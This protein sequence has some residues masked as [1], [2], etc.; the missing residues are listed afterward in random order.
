MQCPFCGDTH[1][2]GTAVCPQ[3]QRRLAGILTDGTVVDGKY[4]ISGIIGVG[5]MAAVYRAENTKIG[6]IVALK[7]LLPEY[8]VYPE[9][10]ARVDRE[11]R[12]AGGIDHPNVVAIVDLGTTAD[13]GPYI[14]MELLKGEEL[15]TYL[16][17]RG[18]T[19][20]PVEAVEITRQVLGA[21]DAAHARGVVHRDLK[22]ENIFL[23]RVD[24]DRLTVKVL[25]F[26]ISKLGKEEKG[27]SSLTRTGTVMGTPQ[28]MAPEQAAGAREQDARVDI[29]ACGAVLYAMLSNALP[30]NAE[31]Y[32]LLINE[33]LNKPATP[34]LDRVPRLDVKLASIV[35]RAIARRPD[36]RY[37]TARAMQDALLTWLD[38][39][40][41]DREPSSSRTIGSAVT[42]PASAIP[43]GLRAGGTR[44]PRLGSSPGTKPLELR[45]PGAVPT[46]ASSTAGSDDPTRFA[47]APPRSRDLFDSV[48]ALDD[49]GEDHG[50]PTVADL[51]APPPEPL[52]LPTPRRSDTRTP[53]GW[54]NTPGGVVLPR[55]PRGRGIAI[56]ALLVIAIIAAGAALRTYDPMAW[57]KAVATV[58]LNNLTV[59]APSG[60]TTASQP[61]T[62]ATTTRGAHTH[63][64]VPTNGGTQPGAHV[65][66]PGADDVQAPSNTV[67]PTT[68]NV[69]NGT[70]ANPAANTTGT[71]RA[72]GRRAPTRNG[73][74]GPHRRPTHHTR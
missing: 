32:N 21:L 46:P 23:A 72:T 51:A 27:V 3:T 36:Q 8:V 22:P 39:N 29:Y 67:E 57:N 69:N 2:P 61:T 14:A 44:P 71:P 50:E 48:E 66:P 62:P 7:M 13:H 16:E 20:H 64:P 42:I 38:A 5:G 6:R 30:Y 19:L 74:R 73:R 60:V 55:P 4:R 37:P 45:R 35:M 52:T 25:D 12:A 1:A 9:L 68:P 43:A 56:A 24:D 15:A 40:V 34:I 47:K 49:G 11:A 10:T 26:G 18:G 28:F 59:P 54:E 31:N 65:A 53:L 63:V 70:N 33:I 17:R 58:G 41:E